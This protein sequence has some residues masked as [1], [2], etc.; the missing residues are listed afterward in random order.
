MLC[1]CVCVCIAASWLAE[2]EQMTHTHTP[3]CPTGYSWFEAVRSSPTQSSMQGS[4]VCVCVLLYDC[5]Y[6]RVYECV[7][8]H[9]CVGTCL[10]C[11]S[12]TDCLSV[13]PQSG[14]Q[15]RL[16]LLFGLSLHELV[17][18]ERVF[19]VQSCRVCKANSVSS[20]VSACDS[21]IVTDLVSL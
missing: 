13:C 10:L 3:P 5:V 16:V 4:Q 14:P 12:G 11:V 7:C 17:Q 2:R 1:V 19:H 18:K 6:G 21:G 9:E 8:V 15:W 20:W